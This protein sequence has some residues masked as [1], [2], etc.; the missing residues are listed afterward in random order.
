MCE[1]LERR[2]DV[3]VRTKKKVLKRTDNRKIQ[4]FE[5]K[6]KK[7]MSSYIVWHRERANKS[8]REQKRPRVREQKRG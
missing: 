8:E 1:K 2:K 7:K 3:E 6:R 4:C 5:R